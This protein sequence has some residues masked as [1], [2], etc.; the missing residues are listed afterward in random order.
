MRG[1]PVKN[2]FVC[3]EMEFTQKGNNLLPTGGNSFFSEKTAFQK[4]LGVQADGL[5]LL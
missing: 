5:S 1:K 2:Y 3:S 4:G